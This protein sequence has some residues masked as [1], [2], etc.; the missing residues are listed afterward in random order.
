MKEEYKIKVDWLALLSSTSMSIAIL[1]AWFLSEKNIY[2]SFIFFPVAVFFIFN[3]LAIITIFRYKIAVD[4]SVERIEERTLVS[5]LSLAIKEI[6]K[7]HYEIVTLSRG[8]FLPG[9]RNK[10][11][12]ELMVED[13]FIKRRWLIEEAEFLKIMESFLRINK[14]IKITT[15]HPDPNLTGISHGESFNKSFF[16]KK[17]DT[18]YFPILIF[19]GLFLLFAIFIFLGNL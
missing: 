10:V 11:L 14:N 7:I 12:V 16:N 1:I 15:E 4:N 18:K 13:R 3:I 2:S 8:A 5:T 19:F 17:I 6:D 9:I